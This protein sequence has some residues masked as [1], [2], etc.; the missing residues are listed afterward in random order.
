MSLWVPGC[1]W[2]CSPSLGLVVEPAG[3]LIAR[4]PELPSFP[5][6]TPCI[7]DP[8]TDSSRQPRAS[9]VD[10]RPREHNMRVVMFPWQWHRPT[11][12]ESG[13]NAFWHWSC[14]HLPLT[15]L[16]HLRSSSKPTI[17]CTP[18]K[19]TKTEKFPLLRALHFS[20]RFWEE[21]QRQE[22]PVEAFQTSIFLQS[23]MGRLSWLPYYMDAHPTYPL[24]CPWPQTQHLSR[25][26]VGSKQTSVE[27]VEL[28]SYDCKQCENTPNKWFSCALGTV[29]PYIKWKASVW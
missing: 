16:L 21:S 11:L 13:G 3:L 19:L 12:A 29:E 23:G 4:W 1:F 5:N 15:P 24:G 26:T 28:K 20:E 27:F 8:W 17:P 25:H 18:Y 2:I 6:K 9:T 22:F 10:P 14:P 7:S